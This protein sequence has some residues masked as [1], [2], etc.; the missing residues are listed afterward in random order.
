MKCTAFL[1]KVFFFLKRPLFPVTF[2]M[3]LNNLN[4]K[5]GAEIVRI[6]TLES[7]KREHDVQKSETSHFKFSECHVGSDHFN[8]IGR[9][10]KDFGT[11]LS[12]ISRIP[13]RISFEWLLANWQQIFLLRIS[14]S[15]FLKEGVDPFQSKIRTW[16]QNH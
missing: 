4:W 3:T 15:N 11:L 13:E 12:I 10:W 6:R 8:V 1:A 14:F 9:I 7:R 5:L 2:G 16:T